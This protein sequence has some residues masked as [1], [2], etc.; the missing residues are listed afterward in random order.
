MIYIILYND[1][2]DFVCN[3]V[4]DIWVVFEDKVDN[5][6]VVYVILCGGVFVVFVLFGINLILNFVDDFVKVD[7]IMDDLIDIG[8]IV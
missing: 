4:C 7:F 1:L 2:N 8:V 6:F 3:C 5:M